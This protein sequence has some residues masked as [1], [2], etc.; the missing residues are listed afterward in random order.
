MKLSDS[1]PQ[2]GMKF[3]MQVHNVYILVTGHLLRSHLFSEHNIFHISVTTLSPLSSEHKSH[4]FQNSDARILGFVAIKTKAC[5]SFITSTLDLHMPA[6]VS[7]TGISELELRSFW[8]YTHRHSHWKTEHNSGTTIS[9][10][11]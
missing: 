8:S 2:S 6:Q 5:I 4:F 10:L 11:P 7:K 3:D 1:N 9:S